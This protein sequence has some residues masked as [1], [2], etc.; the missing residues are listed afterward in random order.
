MAKLPL[1]LLMLLSALPSPG[2]LLAP[3][4]VPQPQ[5]RRTPCT[6]MDLAANDAAPSQ[7]RRTAQHDPLDRRIAQHDP[8]ERLR[9]PQAVN[10]RITSAE[11]SILFF[12]ARWCA[13]CRAL[14]NRLKRL[15]AANVFF[16][17][18]DES[19]ETFEEHEISAVPTFSFFDERGALTE[20]WS[21]VTHRD[22]RE[23]EEAIRMRAPRIE[24]RYP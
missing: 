11:P 17:D 21:R 8:L 14:Q 3:T 5:C 22:W 18:Y 12:G 2:A 16:V 19:K 1:P 6:Q 9:T 4:A 20:Q 7:L 15:A 23:L 13:S 24:Q 10:E